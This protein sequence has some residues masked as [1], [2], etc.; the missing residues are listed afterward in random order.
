MLWRPEPFNVDS[1]GGPTKEMNYLQ[2]EASTKLYQGADMSRLEFIFWI[3]TMQ[4]QRLLTILCMDDVLGGMADKL[5]PKFLNPNMPHTRAK[6]RRIL[7][8][9]G[10]DYKVYDACPCDHTFYYGKK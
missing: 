8:E 1:I 3:L 6:A 10:L 4:S 9:I 2:Q 5:I 7:I